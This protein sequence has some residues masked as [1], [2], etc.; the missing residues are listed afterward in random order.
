[1][2][3]NAEQAARGKPRDKNAET[4]AGGN[5]RRHTVCPDPGERKRKRNATGARRT[6][7]TLQNGDEVVPV[8]SGSRSGGSGDHV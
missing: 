5:D 8:R 4:N 3:D 1:M 7:E 6:P 2:T